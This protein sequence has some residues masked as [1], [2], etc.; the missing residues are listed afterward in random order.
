MTR[1]LAA[2]AL[3]IACVTGTVA[4]ASANAG[5][6]ERLCPTTCLPGC[7]PD[8]CDIVECAVT[9]LPACIPDPLL[10]CFYLDPFGLVCI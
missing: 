6:C 8:V 4:P 1:L 10:K 5:P 7:I 9:C 2:S 3:A